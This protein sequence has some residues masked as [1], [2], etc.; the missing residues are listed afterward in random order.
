LIIAVAKN[1]NIEVSIISEKSYED[2]SFSQEIKKSA[3]GTIKIILKPF[4]HL[5]TWLKHTMNGDLPS[6]KWLNRLRPCPWVS[7]VTVYVI[8]KF[9]L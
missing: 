7:C 4:N 3:N 5:T 8:R 9:P 2:S 1:W 6:M